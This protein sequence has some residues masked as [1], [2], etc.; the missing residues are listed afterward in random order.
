MNFFIK[1][2]LNTHTQKFKL[3]QTFKNACNAQ[4]QIFKHLNKIDFISQFFPPSRTFGR[5]INLISNPTV[6][7]RRLFS[8]V[9]FLLWK[10]F[11]WK[12]K[13]WHLPFSLCR[14]RASSWPWHLDLKAN[15]S[16]VDLPRISPGLR[17]GMRR[18]RRPFSAHFHCDSG[19]GQALNR[20][21]KGL[22]PGSANLGRGR[23]SLDSVATM[24]AISAFLENRH[25]FFLFFLDTL[26]KFAY[27]IR[28]SFVLIQ[29][30]VMEVGFG[31]E[32]VIRGCSV[33]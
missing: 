25:F 17:F 28:Q 13:K 2:L 33:S 18:F 15:S 23:S 21:R 30:G 10:T 22:V 9:H 29:P 5:A 20:S 1:G 27:W 31:P 6:L 11:V 32:F 19:Q 16:S 12:K 24:L 8:R 14:E 4:F 26:F 7:F 3:A